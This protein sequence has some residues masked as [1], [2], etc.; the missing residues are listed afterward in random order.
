MAQGGIQNIKSKYRHV[1]GYIRTTTNKVYW[2]IRF[3]NF[4]KYKINTE[5]EAAIEADKYL[6]S[7]GKPPVNILKPI[8]KT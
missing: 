1:E 4:I 6:I 8:I 3:K 7:I 2:R 5:R